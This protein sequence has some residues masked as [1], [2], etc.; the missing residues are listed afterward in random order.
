MARQPRDEEKVSTDLDLAPFMNMVVILIP[1]LLLSVVFI[2]IGVINI[3]A[4]KLSMGPPSEEKP[5]PDEKPLNLTVAISSKG[6]HLGAQDASQPEMAGCPKPG[7]TICLEKQDVDVS[8]KF[9]A[10]RSA[11]QNGNTEV[12]TKALQD[13]VDA[14]NFR[15]LYNMLAKVKGNFPDETV[16]KLSGDPDVPYAVLVRVMDVARYKLDKDSY[17]KTSAFW[18]ADYK[19]KGTNYTELFNDP[20][21]TIAQ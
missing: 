2:K 21:L 17:N 18:K 7:P 8:A 13:A 19:K 3:T 14:Y 5:D 6:F 4:P 10:A 12:G 15:E 1:L 9:K 11:F 16:V 20:V